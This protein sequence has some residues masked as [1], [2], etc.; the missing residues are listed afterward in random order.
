MIKEPIAR[1][2]SWYIAVPRYRRSVVTDR[3]SLSHH[4]TN[5][6]QFGADKDIA[7]NHANSPS[8]LRMAQ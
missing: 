8:V 4:A 7:G 6:L 3:V 5:I 2:A 1:F